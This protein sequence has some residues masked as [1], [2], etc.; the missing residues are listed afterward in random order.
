[1]SRKRPADPVVE[2]LRSRLAAID[3]SIVLG[4]RARERT[5]QELFAYKRVASIPL[6]DLD[7]ERLVRRRVRA[8]AEAYGVDPDL[9]EGVVVRAIRS[10]KRRFR[11]GLADARDSASPVVVFVRAPEP[12]VVT[13][14]GPPRPAVAV[15]G[16]PAR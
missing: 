3:R 13:S 14:P 16:S 2:E 11:R 12:E 8:W 1:M 10:G 7:Q 15:L 4:L 9:A 5:Q 6:V